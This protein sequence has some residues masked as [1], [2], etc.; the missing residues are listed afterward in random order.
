MPAS[1]GD[2]GVNLLRALLLTSLHSEVVEAGDAVLL[3]KAGSIALLRNATALPY[4]L[5]STRCKPYL[6]TIPKLREPSCQKYSRDTLPQAQL[7]QNSPLKPCHPK[8]ARQS[9]YTVFLYNSWSVKT[10][11]SILHFVVS[12][13][14]LFLMLLR[15][16]SRI[17]VHAV[18]EQVRVKVNLS[19]RLLL[20][21]CSSNS[22][23]IK[24]KSFPANLLINLLSFKHL[25]LWW[26]KRCS[27]VI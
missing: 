25:P 8:T 10:P 5:L 7:R 27:S 26:F 11:P 4:E 6:N 24:M 22:T 16:I 3:C 23:W 9:T 12:E 21:K 2:A 1:L 20:L 18:G 14:L 17:F 15:G 13:L 19:A